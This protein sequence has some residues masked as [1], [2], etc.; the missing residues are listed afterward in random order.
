VWGKGGGYEICKYN[1]I[2][3]Y[4]VMRY[5]SKEYGYSEGIENIEKSF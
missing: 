2:C 4:N 3:K 1:K 5:A